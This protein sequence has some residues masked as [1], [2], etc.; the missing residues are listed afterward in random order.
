MVNVRPVYDD[1]VT[2]SCYSY[3]KLSIGPER[4][5]SN[6]FALHRK[7]MQTKKAEKASVTHRWPMPTSG[8][9]PL[10]LS[11]VPL[12]HSCPCTT[13]RST[14]PASPNLT[15]QLTCYFHIQGALLS[16]VLSNGRGHLA[17]TE[18]VL[19]AEL[20]ALGHTDDNARQTVLNYRED[21]VQLPNL[22]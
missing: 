14:Q 12:Q 18:P 19:S 3:M 8:R 15:L 4:A 1:F 22:E 2:S 7:V 13:H 6:A 16:T 9:C 20:R 11:S 5:P 10:R 17:L 21:F